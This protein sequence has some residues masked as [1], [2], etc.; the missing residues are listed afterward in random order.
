MVA[1]GLTLSNHTVYNPQFPIVFQLIVF[2]FA[3][4]ISLLAAASLHRWVEKPFHEFGKHLAN[5]V[6]VGGR[7]GQ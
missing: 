3:V 1:I 2:I 4:P 7:I 6:I 5:R